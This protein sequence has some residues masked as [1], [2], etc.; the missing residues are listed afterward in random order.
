MGEIRSAIDIA[1]EKTAHIQGDKTSIDNRELKNTGKKAAGEYLSKNDTTILS[2]LIE[3]KTADQKKLLIEGAVSVFLAGLHLPS[4]EHDLKKIQITGNGLDA[5]LPGSGMVQLFAQVDKILAQYLEERAHL[6]Q[7]LEQQFLPRLRAKQ[8][9][10][11]KR[12]GQS[13]PMDVSQDP[14]YVNALTKNNQ[15]LEQK[16][17]TVIDEIRSR[18]REIAGI[19]A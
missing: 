2:T 17:E 5:L 15:M 9:E 7:S 19:E 16:Y 3:G 1:L 18:V 10:I 12:Y 11:A 14:E 13:I 4:A 8:Q 6:A